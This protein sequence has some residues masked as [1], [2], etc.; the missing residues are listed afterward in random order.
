MCCCILV[1]VRVCVS[2]WKQHG[3]VSYELWGFFIKDTHTWNPWIICWTPCE[4]LIH[5]NMQVVWA[6][7]DWCKG[8]LWGSYLCVR[9]C[10]SNCGLLIIALMLKLELA[11]SAVRMWCVFEPEVIQQELS[12]PPDSR[13]LWC[14]HVSLSSH[15]LFSSEE[16]LTFWHFVCLLVCGY[17]V[18]RDIHLCRCKRPCPPLECIGRNVHED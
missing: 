4:Y 16:L 18:N 15:N 1:C 13:D 2:K 7:S 8:P 12:N 5:D 3:F 10:V 11:L 6:N 9:V 17:T 14:L